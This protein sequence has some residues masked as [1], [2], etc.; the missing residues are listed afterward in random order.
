MQLDHEYQGFA[1]DVKPTDVS[2][3]AEILKPLIGMIPMNFET[4]D[5]LKDALEKNAAGASF[6]KLTVDNKSIFCKTGNIPIYS[7]EHLREIF[8]IAEKHNLPVSCHNHRKWGFDRITQYPIHSLEHMIGDADLSETDILHMAKHNISIVP[9]MTIAQSYLLEEAYANRN[10]ARDLH[11]ERY[12]QTVS[13]RFYNERNSCA[14][15]LPDKRST[16][17]L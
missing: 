11:Y 15:E 4:M 13:D 9:T 14:E 6:I 17:P 3:F 7:D 8:N 10:K 5:D 16:T 1:P 2:I 12:P